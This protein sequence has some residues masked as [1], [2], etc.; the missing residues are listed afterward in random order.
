MVASSTTVYPGDSN[1]AIRAS[2]RP[3]VSVVLAARDA[4]ATLSRALESVLGQAFDAVQLVAVVMPSRDRTLSICE[5]AAERNVRLDVVEADTL[6]TLAAFDAGLEVARGSYVLFMRQEDWLGPR[7]LERLV[8]AAA[9]DGLDAALPQRSCDSLDAHGERHS[10]IEG[11]PGGVYRSESAFRAHAHEF[12]EDGA[13]DELTGKLFSRTRI[14]DLALRAGLKRDET[15][16]LAT[17]FEDAERVASVENAVYHAAELPVPETVLDRELFERCERAYMRLREM[18]R[19]WGMGS[20]EQLALAIHRSHL[21]RIISCIEEVCARRNIPSIER[22][23][24]VR[25]MIEAPSTREAVAALRGVGGRDLGIMYGPIARKNA[26]ICC[27]SARFAPLFGSKAGRS[28][29][30]SHRDA[31]VA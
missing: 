13:F 7:A 20:D 8:D 11:A 5:H 27:L 10:R 21:L 1:V 4:E 17:F 19:S 24:R 15:D 25:D 14:D 31:A 9:R 30:T 29:S 3:S 16:Y 22:C 23:A 18:A 28:S 6:D 12:V 2:Q 26:L